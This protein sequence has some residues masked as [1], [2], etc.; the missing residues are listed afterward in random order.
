MAVTEVSREPIPVHIRIGSERI[1]AGSGG[2]HERINPSTGKV[3]SLIPLAG[4]EE[5][6]RAVEV[7]HEAFQGW[8]RTPPA[9]RRRLLLKLADLMDANATETS[10]L[11]TIDKWQ[12]IRP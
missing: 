5:V 6:N 7:T 4:P 3:D 9:E 8:R 2:T 12:S 10:R 1:K 11:A